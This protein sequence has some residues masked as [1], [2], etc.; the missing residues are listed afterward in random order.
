MSILDKLHSNINLAFKLLKGGGGEDYCWFCQMPFVDVG[1]EF[2]EQCQT[3]R[4]PHCGGCY[5]SLSPEAKQALDMEQFSLGLW[6][7]FHN[8][9]KRKRRKRG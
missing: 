2:C 6:D 1:A 8:P 9:P 7:P 3:F 5:C 4:C